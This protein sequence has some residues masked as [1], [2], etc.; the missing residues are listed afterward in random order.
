M[1][2]PSFQRKSPGDPYSRAL[3]QVK[4]HGEGEYTWA[5]G[6]QGA[7]EDILGCQSRADLRGHVLPGPVRGHVQSPR[8]EDTRWDL[9]ASVPEQRAISGVLREHLGGE[10]VTGKE[11]EG[12]P[13]SG[14]GRELKTCAIHSLCQL[15]ILW[16]PPGP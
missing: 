6:R 11:D 3:G 10:I 1:P 2:T 12:P 5:L 14:P 7:L 13:A 8:M 9:C 15:A 16:W 4:G